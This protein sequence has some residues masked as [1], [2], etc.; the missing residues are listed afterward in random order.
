MHKT[1]FVNDVY[2]SVDYGILS[3][4]MF[5]HAVLLSLVSLNLNSL[6][7]QSCFFHSFAC[8]RSRGIGSRPVFSALLSY[9]SGKRQFN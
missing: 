6:S 4:I 1:Y 3:L 9:S 7:R 2:S 5:C 8:S